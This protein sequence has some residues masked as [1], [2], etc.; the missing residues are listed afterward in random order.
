MPGVVA[1]CSGYV[2]GRVDQP[3]YE[4]VSRGTTGHTEAIQVLFDPG[5]VS[6]SKLCE[7]FWD[8]LGDD[9]MKPNQVGNDYGPQYRSGIYAL[10]A[11]QLDAARASLLSRQEALA[12]PIATEVEMQQGVFWPAEEYH[13][14]YLSKGGRFGK[15]QSAEKGATDTI[16][17]YG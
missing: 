11:K 2:Q 15:P 6:Y 7:L 3:T 9:A 5:V 1:T 14:Q 10:D 4:E 13:Q 17:C 16:R 12:R 8:R